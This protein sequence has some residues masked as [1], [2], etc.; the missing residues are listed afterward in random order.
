LK[1]IKCG[2]CGC[3]LDEEHLSGKEEITL[4]VDSDEKGTITDV[5]FWCAS[6]TSGEGING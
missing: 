2:K 1:K 3:S 4:V 6:C 5:K